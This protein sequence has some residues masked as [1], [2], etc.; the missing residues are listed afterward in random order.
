[1]ELTQIFRGTLELL[2]YGGL[3]IFILLIIAW[4]SDRADR[5]Q[6]CGGRLLHYDADPYHDYCE[7]GC[8]RDNS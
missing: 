5:C 7:N 8:P 4:A 2:K 3:L 6:V 1:M